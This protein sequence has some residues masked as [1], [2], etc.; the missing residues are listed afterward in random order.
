MKSH[1]SL[2]KKPHIW[3]SRD[4][5]LWLCWSHRRGVD[6]RGY[7]RTPKEAFDDLMQWERRMPWLV[8]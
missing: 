6:V 3:W 1:L 4:K 5:R 7:G 8:R 2:W